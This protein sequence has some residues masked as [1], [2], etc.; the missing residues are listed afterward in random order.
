[1]KILKL[2]F[3]TAFLGATSSA[4]AFIMSDVHE[5]NRNLI[6][7]EYVEFDF[8]LTGEGYNSLTDSITNIK[9]S[10]DL[11]EIV[12]TEENP[13]DAPGN[14][15]WEFVIFY[16]WMFNGREYFLDVDTG[17]LTFETPWSKN[18][19]CQFYSVVD[20]DETCVQNLDLYGNMPSSL[21]VG[22]NNLWLGEARL[23]VEI[24]RTS[25]PEPSSIFLLGLG[26]F[27]LVVK[28]IRLKKI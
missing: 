13:E 1:M 15:D 26:L 12:E 11:R 21:F 2:I 25:I 28:Q 19:D 9:V 3:I 24:N 8:D 18:Y 5:I 16:S 27:G 6:Q 14:D 7:G 20:G 10:L 23:D 22:T 17:T 4:N